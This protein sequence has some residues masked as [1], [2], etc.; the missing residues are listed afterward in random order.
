MLG[1]TW[2]K[3]KCISSG[4]QLGVHSTFFLV[5]LSF[6]FFSVVAVLFHHWMNLLTSHVYQQLLVDEILVNELFQQEL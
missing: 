2:S 5:F 3:S 4:F 1:S 6:V